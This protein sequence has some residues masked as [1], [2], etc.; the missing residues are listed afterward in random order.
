MVARRGIDK[1]VNILS[2]VFSNYA[3][4]LL[5][6]KSYINMGSTLKG[7]S[8][9]A[10][11]KNFNCYIWNSF[12]NKCFIKP[13]MLAKKRLVLG[14]GQAE[15][16]YT[17]VYRPGVVEHFYTSVTMQNL[18]FF[19]MTFSLFCPC[20]SNWP[21]W[22]SWLM[23]IPLPCTSTPSIIKPSGQW[24]SGQHQIILETKLQVCWLQRQE[25]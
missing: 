18:Y 15:K 5:Y 17:P 19:N 10:L 22:A 12:W 4:L 23:H 24:G 21:H 16:P 8:L 2:N 6:A 20:D 3:S 1:S 7:K 25:F 9:W 13:K 11:C 14:H